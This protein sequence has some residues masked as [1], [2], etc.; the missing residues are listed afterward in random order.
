ML[1]GYSEDDV[2]ESLCI[3][4]G[5]NCYRGS[6]ADLLDRHYQVAL[7]YN[8]DAIVKI[9]S[10]CPLI[11]PFIIDRV[12]NH[13]IENFQRF[14]YVSNLHPP[15]YPDGNDV[16]IMSVTALEMAWK[17]A[18][19]LLEREHT[20]PYFWD[21]PH[22]FAIGNVIWESGLNYSST[23]RW[24]IDYK[25]DYLFISRVYDELYPKKQNFGLSDILTLLKTKPEIA[26]INRKYSG[27]YWYENHLDELQHI[28]EFKK[29][30]RVRSEV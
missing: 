24:T 10:D 17:K 21:N 30:V 7:A 22:M 3:E 27:R 16:E 6:L 18:S 15:T 2:I 29:L 19:R 8:A 25:E 23:H 28:D 4:N 12:I 9:P 13:F 20:T 26:E 14:D 11:D 1:R 5:I